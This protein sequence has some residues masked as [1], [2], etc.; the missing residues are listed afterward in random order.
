VIWLSERTLRAI[1][2]ATWLGFVP[3]AAGAQPAP[4][5][6]GPQAWEQLPRLQL[7]GQFA[8]PLRDTLIQRWRDPQT[9]MICYVYLPI[10]A[11]HSPPTPAGYVQYG[12]N[13]I[14]SISCAAAPPVPAP[15]PAP[16]PRR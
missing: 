4:A 16:A 15:A 13:A 3:T 5:A 2:A 11:P 8:G 1:L 10:T 12:P 6:P 14:G 9:N 7:E